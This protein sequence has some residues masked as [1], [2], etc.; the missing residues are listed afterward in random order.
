[1]LFQIFDVDDFSDKAPLSAHDYIGRVEVLLHE[2][3]GSPHQK[4]TRTILN[5][6]RQNK[7]NGQLTLSLNNNDTESKELIKLVFTG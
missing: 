5:E 7:K 2:I 6:R 4:L 1:M 3:V